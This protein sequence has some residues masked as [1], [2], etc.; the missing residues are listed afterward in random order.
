MNPT[1]HN[2]QA[3]IYSRATD[4]VYEVYLSDQK[5]LK[6]MEEGAT[7]V[8]SSA[9][10]QNREEL[11]EALV[12]H[13]MSHEATLKDFLLLDLSIRRWLN[14]RRFGITDT[15]LFAAVPAGAREGDIICVLNGGRVPYVL[16]RSGEWHK[17]TLVGECYVDEM[18]RG[19]AQVRS[20]AKQCERRFAIH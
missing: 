6:H 20:P 8:G 13:I 15:G 14:H 7:A 10:R 9:H 2:A 16:R 18:M 3:T 5:A 17:F 19:E 1:G 12:F 11:R 4:T